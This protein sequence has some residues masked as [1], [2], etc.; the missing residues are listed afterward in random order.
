MNRSTKRPQKGP[1]PSPPG[2]R[3]RRVLVH[4]VNERPRPLFIRV[5]EGA[6]YF[7]EEDITTPSQMRKWDEEN[8]RRGAIDKL[9]TPGERKI[10][11]QYCRLRDD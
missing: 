9:L 5:G 1:G 3:G 2:I 4:L 10:F 7:F 6:F 11:E 8:I